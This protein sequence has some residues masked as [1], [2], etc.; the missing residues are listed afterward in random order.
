MSLERMTWKTTLKLSTL[1]RSMGNHAKQKRK[2]RR[3][4]A[5][6][7]LQTPKRKP[8]ELGKHRKRNRHH[9]IP[10]SRGG[11][12]SKRNLLLMKIIRH[13]EWHKIFGLMTLDEV[14]ELLIR[15]RDAK[16]HQK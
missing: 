4:K 5:R 2:K 6:S 16:K 3:A 7:G 10:K 15:V 1:G 14:I 13:N 11:S 9:L 12:K 8:S